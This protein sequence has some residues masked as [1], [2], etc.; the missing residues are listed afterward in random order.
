MNNKINIAFLDQSH[1]FSGA[2]NSLFSLIQQIDPE[3]YESTLIFIYPKKH[4]KRFDVN[5]H[6][7]WLEPKIQWWM[8]SDRWQNPLRGT[9]LIKRIVLGYKL[10]RW[11]KKNSIDIVHINLMEPKSFW[12]GFWLK[13]FNVKSVIHIRSQSWSWMP[14]AKVQKQYDAIITVSNYVKKR[15]QTKFLHDNIT[16]IYNP[17]KIMEQKLQMSREELFSQLHIDNSKDIVSSVGLLA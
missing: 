4:Q 17:V 14:S 1:V 3:Q 10:A 15:V 9:D 7:T 2:E 11:A 8:G 16:S 13:W 6:K 5:C 12:W